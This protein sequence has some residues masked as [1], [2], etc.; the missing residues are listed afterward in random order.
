MEGKGAV[1]SEEKRKKRRV[2]SEKRMYE[3]EE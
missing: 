3:G 2:D 1:Q